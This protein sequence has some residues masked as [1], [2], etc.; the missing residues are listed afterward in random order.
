MSSKLVDTKDIPL[1]V[2]IAGGGA[3]GALLAAHLL[4]SGEVRVALIE[5]DAR[6]GRGV[7]YGTNFPGHL[8]NVPAASLSQPGRALQLRGDGLVRAGGSVAA[9]ALAALG[10]GL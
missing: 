9:V 6:L 4:R 8:M 3:G 1:T 2:A 7:A 5:R 10:I